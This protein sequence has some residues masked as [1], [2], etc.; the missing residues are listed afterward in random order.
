VAGQ[1]SGMGCGVLTDVYHIFPE[2]DADVA[3]ATCPAKR[4]SV[5]LA[6]PTFVISVSLIAALASLADLYYPPPMGSR[7]G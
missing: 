1:N 5:L 7:I 4:P 2:P 6:L 3:L